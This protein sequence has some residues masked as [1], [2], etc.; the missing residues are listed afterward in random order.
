MNKFKILKSKELKEGLPYCTTDIVS[1]LNRLSD[2]YKVIFL[3]EED[4]DNLIKHP[5]F[6]HHYVNYAIVC[7]F[8]KCFY[9]N[10]KWYATSHDTDKIQFI[11]NVLK[12]QKYY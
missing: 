2:G 10:D 9:F 8:A 11:I 1:L 4:Y 5:A 3:E 12:D 6:T 7:P